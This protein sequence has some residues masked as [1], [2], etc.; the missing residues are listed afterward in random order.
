MVV[1]K[2][3]FQQSLSWNTSDFLK[4]AEEQAHSCKNIQIKNDLWVFA[5]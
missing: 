5:D 1:Y 4:N 2:K 3:S